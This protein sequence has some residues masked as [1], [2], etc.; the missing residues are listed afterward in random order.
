MTVIER[1]FKLEYNKV[2]KEKKVLA[3]FKKENIFCVKIRKYYSRG[4]L[5]S[6]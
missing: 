2:S 3:R 6:V 5:Y 4:H 1:N